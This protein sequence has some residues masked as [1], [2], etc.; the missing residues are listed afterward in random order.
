MVVCK[1]ALL[2]LQAGIVPGKMSKICPHNT[3][4]RA[5]YF[6]GEIVSAVLTVV[7]CILMLMFTATSRCIRA[8]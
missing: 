8:T 3:T 6:G 1:L 4:G 5:D 2:G 7:L